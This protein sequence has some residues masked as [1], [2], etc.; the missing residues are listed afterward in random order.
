MPAGATVV[1]S[2]DR[3]PLVANDPHAYALYFG[4][5]T[6]LS[7]PFGTGVFPE[8][9]LLSE[10]QIAAVPSWLTGTVSPLNG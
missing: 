9:V 6:H 4:R 1:A 7:R 5:K 8:H 3:F 10:A 2:E